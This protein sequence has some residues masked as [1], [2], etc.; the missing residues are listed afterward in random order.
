MTVYE[1]VLEEELH[2]SSLML[3]YCVQKTSAVR[4]KAPEIMVEVKLD[5]NIT[6]MELDTGAAVSLISRKL[7]CTVFKD[8]SRLQDS[9]IVL[10]TLTGSK[11]PVEGVCYV[12]VEVQGQTL[13]G[14]PLYVVQGDGPALFGR[15]WL[16]KVKLNWQELKVNE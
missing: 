11:I 13:C 3:N 10:K 2:D 5:G 9:N 4:P 6:H 1:E 14:V 7:Y 8:Q 12:D 15:D 16:Q